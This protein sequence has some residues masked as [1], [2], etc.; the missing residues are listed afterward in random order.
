MKSKLSQPCSEFQS[1]A[2]AC[3]EGADNVETD[4][5]RFQSF[6]QSRPEGAY[7]VE[8][9][10]TVLLSDREL[11]TALPTKDREAVKAHIQQENDFYALLDVN[12]H[13][14]PDEI[15]KNYHKLMYVIHPNKGENDPRF[16]AKVNEAYTILMDQDLRRAYDRDKNVP[17]RDVMLA[18]HTTGG[19]YRESHR[20]SNSLSAS[21]DVHWA[22]LLHGDHVY[23]LM[24]WLLDIAHHGVVVS[25]GETREDI[26]IIDFGIS[27]RGRGGNEVTLVREV[28]LNDFLP[29]KKRLK[30]AKYRAV[31]SNSVGVYNDEPDPDSVV[32]QRA[33]R[34]CML[35]KF[36]YHLLSQNCETVAFWCKTGRRYAGQYQK[37]LNTIGTRVAVAVCAPVVVCAVAAYAWNA[38]CRLEKAQPLEVLNQISKLRD[39]RD[40]SAL[41]EDRY[42][43]DS[44]NNFAGI[45]DSCENIREGQLVNALEMPKY[46]AKECQKHIDDFL[47]HTGANGD[48]KDIKEF[49]VQVLVRCQVFNAILDLPQPNPHSN[50]AWVLTK[51]KEAEFYILDAR[52]LRIRELKVDTI[53]T[54]TSTDSDD[55]VILHFTAVAIDHTGDEVQLESTKVPNDFKTLHTVLT[56]LHPKV[57]EEACP[58]SAD[59]HD[60]DKFNNY[61]KTLILL[62]SCCF[63]HSDDFVMCNEQ[64]LKVLQATKVRE[65]V[66]AFLSRS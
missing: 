2:Q 31:R 21:H 48:P 27:A 9:G 10:H 35:G 5:T 12:K 45:L 64:Y 47:R 19:H 32:V 11:D 52:A 29:E 14:K 24:N 15:R 6:A 46:V 56:E 57:K 61:L 49:L 22:E 63:R 17:R 1:F 66:V 55:D 59:G 44:V 7:N 65:Q 60:P 51:M 58:S 53:K 16:S 34:L 33:R 50:I 38:R 41:V 40:V 3:P 20:V 39:R 30:R 25:I 62:S 18:R 26:K 8:T 4:H 37:I 23:F 54:S 42:D 13:A 36:D 43:I 28:S